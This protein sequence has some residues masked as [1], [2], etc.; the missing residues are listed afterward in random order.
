MNTI[1]DNTGRAADALEGM[2]QGNFQK[3]NPLGDIN[4]VNGAIAAAA[5]APAVPVAGGD[6][7]LVTPMEQ[8][9]ASVAESARHL[10]ELVGL[11]QSGGLSFA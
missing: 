4:A 10:R 1:A 7:A 11:A 5:G 9:A 6:E 3:A 8:T 2:L